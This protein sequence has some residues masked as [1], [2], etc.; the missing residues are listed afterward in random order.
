MNKAIEKL[1][2][3]YKASPNLSARQRALLEEEIW[4]KVSNEHKK[5]LGSY[6]R[7]KYLSRLL[8]ENRNQIECRHSLLRAGEAGKPFWK[9]ISSG[10]ITLNA[11]RRL[12]HEARKQA[13]IYN[14]KLLPIVRRL[15]RD[16]TISP[17][18]KV[19]SDTGTYARGVQP[20]KPSSQ[21]IDWAK[22]REPVMAHLL[23]KLGKVN[24]QQAKQIVDD[25]EKDL[26]ALVTRYQQIIYKAAKMYL[27]EERI[28]W[29]QFISA[30]EMLGVDPPTSGGRTKSE[31][32]QIK[33]KFLQRANK[34]Q[35]RLA[36]AYHPDTRGGKED[37]RE[38][39]E[40]VIQAY[41]TLDIFFRQGGVIL[42]VL[43][44]GSEEEEEND[45]S[46]DEEKEATVEVHDASRSS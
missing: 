27:P 20:L 34:N 40:A 29:K 19:T 1:V 23:Y 41:N 9:P 10:E 6:G 22:L 39:Y 18:H 12:L 3:K 30:C 32:E 36:A 14:S 5:V 44:G 35:R 15:L 28:S 7:G 46:S 26:K 43:E 2:D 4:Q 45:S 17:K 42:E 13:T 11:A 24:A 38:L 16:Y 25:F 21:K 37:A 31:R 33:I 8:G